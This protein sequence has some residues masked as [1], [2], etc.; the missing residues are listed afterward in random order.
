MIIMFY[1]M[2]YKPTIKSFFSSLVWNF[3][4]AI[5]AAII[6][7]FGYGTYPRIIIVLDVIVGIIVFVMLVQTIVVH[8][9]KIY[10]DD[11]C[12]MTSG[13]L[14]TTKMRWEEITS[15]TLL[16]RKN[17]MSR[18]DHLLI[19]AGRNNLISYNTSVLSTQDEDTVLKKIMSKT[20]LV[21]KEDKPSI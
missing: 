5:A 14:N 6:T 18:T 16:E 10:V 4:L 2:Y 19:L 21:I 13:L 17:A 20:N 3:S 11:A 7:F 12:L 15:A 1:N 8:C 9:N